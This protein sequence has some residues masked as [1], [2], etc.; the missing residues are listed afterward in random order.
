MKKKLC[1]LLNLCL[2]LVFAACGSGGDVNSTAGNTVPSEPH[3]VTEPAAKSLVL[4]QGAEYHYTFQEG[5]CETMNLIFY[6]TDE[7]HPD[8]GSAGIYM[9][10]LDTGNVYDESF[11]NW[12]IMIKGDRFNLDTRDTALMTLFNCYACNK[13][14]GFLWADNE[15]ITRF[16]QS[17]LDNLAEQLQSGKPVESVPAEKPTT[18]I[19]TAFIYEQA[20]L[21]HTQLHQAV[22]YHYTLDEGCGETLNLL[23][24]EIEEF[25]DL[26]PKDAA[27]GCSGIYMLDMDTGIWYDGSILDYDQMITDDSWNFSTRESALMCF[28]EFF[29]MNRKS[30]RIWSDREQLIRFSEDDLKSINQQLM[31]DELTRKV[32]PYPY[33]SID[34]EP[35]QL[36]NDEIAALIHRPAGYVKTAISTVPDAIAYLDL[37]FPELWMGMSLKNGIEVNNRW[38]RSAVEILSDYESPAARSCI[39]NCITYL[40]DDNYELESLIAFY[41]DL[42]TPNEDGPEKAINCIKT[43]NGYL[44]FDPVLRMQGDAMSRNGSLLPEMSCGSIAEYLEHIRQNPTL[45]SVIKCIFINS[46]GVRMDYIRGFTDGYTITTA[47]PS[48]EIVYYSVEPQEP[49]QHI[50]PENIHKYKLSTMLGGVTL[51]TEE[52]YS[53]VDAAPEV[54]QEKVK[55]AA[56]VLMYMLAAKIADSHGCKCT[57]VN[58]HKW[59]WNMSA[60][61]VMKNKL[62]NCGSCANLANYLL[63]GD[64]EEVGYMDQAYYPGNGGSHVYTYILHEGKYYIIDY[65]WFIFENYEPSRDYAPHVLNSLTEWPEMI[66]YVYG[67]VCLVMA[68]DSPGMQYPVVFGEEYAQEFGDIYYI[69]PEDI[70]YTI[71]HEAPDGYKYHHIPFD[72]SAYNWKTFGVD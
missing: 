35:R 48:I 34:D 32:S 61:E 51:S 52:A 31:I 10:D 67:P 24:F 60:M 72:I 71:L 70:E 7:Y 8:T 26:D 56:D 19:D 43:T 42:D 33:I 11:L 63:D 14:D 39:I 15:T 55:T 65:S 36:S 64:Y 4:I 44:V 59:H 21:L 23:F 6:V 17:Q 27:F 12:D 54:V 28:I 50:K 2:C 68:Y 37:R 45:S 9:V 22:E 29:S 18:S 40:L 62:G 20:K 13:D 41:P 66:P 58:N 3:V 5:C 25:A 46:N 30:N 16:S 47:S 49:E 57:Q 69:L 38:L 53:L 1:L